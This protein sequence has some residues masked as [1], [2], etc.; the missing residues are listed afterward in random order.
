MSKTININ[1]IALKKLP[2]RDGVLLISKIT[3]RVYLIE[4][5]MKRY[6]NTLTEFKKYRKNKVYRVNDTILNLYPEQFQNR[7]GVLFIDEDTN[8]T[9]LIKNKTKDYIDTLEELK[10][11]KKN[12]IYRVN[13]AVLN[14]YSDINN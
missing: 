5:K 6:I 4:N 10:K 8:Q 2:Y 11:Y 7:N 3:K 14:L 9:Y 13:D 12:K 1:R